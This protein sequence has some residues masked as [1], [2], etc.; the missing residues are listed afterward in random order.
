M[1]D[2]DIVERLEKQ[3]EG[4]NLALA[5][6]AEVLHKMDSRLTKAENEEVE[7]SQDQEDEMEK[8]EIIKA[9]AGEVYGLI[10]ADTPDNMG[11]WGEGGDY[12]VK[13]KGSSGSSGTITGKADDSETALNIESD[14][15]KAKR[16]F[17]AMQKQ[18]K[19][20]KEAVG[21]DDDDE[22]ENDE[23]ENV[24]AG[25]GYGMAKDDDSDDEDD[26]DAKKDEDEE[27]YPGI[28][29]M[30]K[31]IASIKKMVRSKN[32]NIQ[33]MVQ[34]ETENRLRKMGFREE[35]GLNS[36]KLIRYEDA[37]GVDNT[38]PIRKA[39]SADDTVDQ[40]MQMSYGELRRLQ[41]AVESGDTDGIPRELLEGF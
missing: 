9:V 16:T 15:A 18:I 33:K 3:I 30:A 12:T 24:E 40:M 1:A 11:Q 28:A 21:M 39:A 5:A 25:Y 20:L 4:S 6:V 22:D 37:L 27:E 17:Q 34:S 10:K 41:E 23:D 7:F 2:S 36:P 14:T 29:A 31:S 8:Q 32:T 35:N 26:D 19:L 13:V 38:P